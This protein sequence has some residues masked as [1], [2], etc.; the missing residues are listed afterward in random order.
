MKRVAS[1]FVRGLIIVVPIALTLWLLGGVFL[2]IDELMRAQLARWLPGVALP[3][4]GF[5]ATIVAITVIGF[6]GSHFFTRGLV[7]AFGVLLERVPVVKMLYGALKDLMKAFVGP[8]R[9]FDQPVLVSFLPQGGG[10]RALG[11]VTRD[12][13]GHLGLPEDV[14]VYFPQAYNF[15][16]Q[17]LVVPRGSVTAMTA[18]SAD[19]MTFI[20]SGGISGGAATK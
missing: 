9:R 19:V 16:G 7:A 20:V 3:G 14:A 13:L 1:Y 8:E 10:P 2:S 18:P 4:I 15:A 12:T 5:L 6:L 11:F 17:L